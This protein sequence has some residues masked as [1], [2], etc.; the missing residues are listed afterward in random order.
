MKVSGR[1]GTT[2]RGG[3]IGLASSAVNN[4]KA[5]I[6]L[7]GPLIFLKMKMPLWTRR[8]TEK[9]AEMSPRTRRTACSFNSTSGKR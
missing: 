6:L 5:G 4:R 8:S 2:G 3:G 9:K 7:A 1:Y